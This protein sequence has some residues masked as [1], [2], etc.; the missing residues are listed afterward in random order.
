MGL[1]VWSGNNPTDLPGVRA[2]LID[3][4]S[5]ARTSLTPN[6]PEPTTRLL[7]GGGLALVAFRRRRL[8]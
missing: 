6:V 3:K 8:S 4:L 5:V 2:N 1:R 7:L